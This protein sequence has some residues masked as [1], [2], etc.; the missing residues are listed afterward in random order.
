[1]WELF[2]KWDTEAFVYLNSLG[3]EPYDSFWI[4]VTQID[5]WVFL[6]VLFGFV[7]F[8]FFPRR[9]GWIVTG[10][11]LVTAILTFFVKFITK[12][13]VERLR[14]SHNPVLS[15]TIRVLQFPVDFSFF[16]GHASVSFA[17]VT[18]L[19]YTLKPSTKWVYL[20]FIWPILFSFS[21]IYV[22]VHYPSDILIGAGIG[23]LMGYIVYRI[24]KEY[25]R[26]RDNSVTSRD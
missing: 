2:K 16:S 14:P 10:F 5:S 22:G 7:I 11:L 26:K 23:T 8:R 13:S 20:F 25:F 17:V 9:K 19:V 18:F 15:D 4:F 3:S 1:M 6:F 21:R 12:L 24:Q